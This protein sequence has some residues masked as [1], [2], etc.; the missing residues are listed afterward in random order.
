M[1]PI[2]RLVVSLVI[3]LTCA[4][5][6]AAEKPAAVY[7]GGTLS[8]Q[9]QWGMKSLASAEA[10]QAFRSLGGRLYVHEIGWASTSLD[11]RQKIGRLFTAPPVWE[12]GMPETQVVT[13]LSNWMWPT[14][15]ARATATCINGGISP[16]QM[17]SIDANT[18]P[19]TYDVGRFGSPNASA[20][21]P[22]WSDASFNDLRTISRRGGVL[23]LDVPPD[24]YFA[25]EEGY[26]KWTA[27]AIRW[28]RANDVRTVMAIYPRVPTFA[29]DAIK[30]IED[31]EKRGSRPTIYAGDVYAAKAD[32]LFP[33]GHEQDPKS[34][35]SVMLTIL[36]RE[37]AK[38]GAP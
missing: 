16:A 8:A 2:A 14:W 24:Y 19:F 27:D 9:G 11:D 1:W 38:Y 26:R 35:T 32:N 18:R 5:A 12:S 34:L 36:R 20:N 31:L 29:T 7:V 21:N 33:L 25:R 13:H 17:V 15:K 28:C 6:G 22:P 3:S 30:L 4:L 10:T 23:C 37:R